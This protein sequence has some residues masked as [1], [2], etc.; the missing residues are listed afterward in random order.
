MQVVFETGS[1]VHVHVLHKV[2]TDVLLCVLREYCLQCS[3][4]EHSCD[5]IMQHFMYTDSSLV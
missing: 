5:V 4:H 3:I 2:L 1:T